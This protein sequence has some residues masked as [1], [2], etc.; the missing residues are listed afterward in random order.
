MQHAGTTLKKI[1]RDAM[2][3]QGSEAPLL[4]WA[5]ACG[6]KTAA[7]A[8]AI[9]FVDG[10]LIVAVPDDAWRRQVQGFRAQYLN[11][12]KQI[13]SEPVNEIHFVIASSAKPD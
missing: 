6:S 12:L 2:R 7:R 1:F 3:Q 11:A 10:V 5:L 8:T 13:T 9:S 4:A